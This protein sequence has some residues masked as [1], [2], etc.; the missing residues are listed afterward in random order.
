MRTHVRSKDRQRDGTQQQV[1]EQFHAT[2]PEEI[3][4]S[5]AQHPL[6]N[7]GPRRPVFSP[8]LS[9]QFLRDVLYFAPNSR[10]ISAPQVSDL[11]FRVATPNQFARDVERF[12][13]VVPAVDSPAAIEVRRALEVS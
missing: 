3:G 1:L 11:F 12:R 13:R 2:S 4:F 9:L 8:L 10:R 5:L 6:T 7:P